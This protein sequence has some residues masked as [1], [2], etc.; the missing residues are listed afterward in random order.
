VVNP[1]PAALRNWV[2]SRRTA[3]CARTMYLREDDVRA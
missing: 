1:S 2:P 3:A